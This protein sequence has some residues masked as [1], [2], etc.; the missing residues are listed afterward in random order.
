[1]AVVHKWAHAPLPVACGTFSV[2]PSHNNS[3]L[4]HH[5][6]CQKNTRP[7]PQHRTSYE[8]RYR[9]LVQNVPRRQNDTWP[10]VHLQSWSVDE[11]GHVS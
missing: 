9:W 1:M 6:P 7:L 8:M 10:P 3:S 11:M 5:T 2:A 4:P